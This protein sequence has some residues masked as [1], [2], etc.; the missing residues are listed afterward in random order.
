MQP[1]GLLHS[2]QQTA[3][4][5]P[6]RELIDALREGLG[7]YARGEIVSPERLVVPMS[8]GVLL[9][10]PASAPDLASHKLVTVCRGNAARGLP[11]ILGAVTAYDPHT[12]AEH[13]SLDAP[14][15]TARRTAAISML[16]IQ[17]LHGPPREVALIGTGAQAS[18]HAQALTALFPAARVWA[19][20]RSMEAAEQFCAEAGAMFSPATS[21]PDSAD[22]VITN[23]TSKTP[24]YSAPARAGRLLIGVGAFTADAA[25]LA[26]ETVRGSRL[27]TD[28]P[29]GA[30][31]EA[32]DLIGAGVDWAQVHALADALHTP[33]PSC[34]TLLKTVG[35]AA[36]DLVACR[37]AL[38]Q[39]GQLGAAG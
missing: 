15:V 23:T 12:G 29:A 39:L 20:S 38:A 11:T 9:S 22:V 13:L 17:L 30:R 37:V 33:P 21:V 10:M 35:C 14:T 25:E 31:H 28:D 6:F 2:A 36:W 1:S 16:G 24:V 5:L 19:V 8:G 3:A 7:Q 4:L 26:P 18:G 34:P 27:Y 32:G